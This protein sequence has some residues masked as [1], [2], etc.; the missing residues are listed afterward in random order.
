[1]VNKDAECNVKMTHSTDIVS[2]GICLNE[3]NWFGT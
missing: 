2:T 3:N 1:M